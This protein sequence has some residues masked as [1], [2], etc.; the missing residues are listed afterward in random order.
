VLAALDGCELVVH[1]GD[2]GAQAVLDALAGAGRRVLAVRGNNDVAD[3]WSGAAAALAA[4]AQEAAVE[5]PGGTLAVVHGDRALP[6]RERHRKLRERFAHARLVVYGHSHRPCI[7]RAQRPW[8]AN[9]GAAGR[10]RTFGGPGLLLLEATPR[11]WHL[12]ARR[13]PPAGR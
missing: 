1:A 3:K 6:A 12:I 2:I 8:V 10:A 5:L 11:R 9:P 7:D 4:L 13:F